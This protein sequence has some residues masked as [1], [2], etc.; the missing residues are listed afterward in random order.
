DHAL[1]MSNSMVDSIK[2]NELTKEEA[3]KYLQRKDLQLI[4]KEKGWHLATYGEHPL[5][6]LNVLSNRINNY[7]PKELRILKDI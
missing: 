7:Y 1:S 4:E 6:W 3:I 5:G 2:K